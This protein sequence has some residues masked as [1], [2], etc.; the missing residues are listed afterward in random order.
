MIEQRKTLV[1]LFVLALLTLGV[2]SFSTSGSFKTLDDDYSIVRNENI[3]SFHNIPKVMTNAFFGGDSYYR[4]LVTISFMKEYHFS[5][6]IRCR[7]ISI[8]F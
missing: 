8:I 2:Y 6:L 3:R 5:N 1:G 7:T 4:P